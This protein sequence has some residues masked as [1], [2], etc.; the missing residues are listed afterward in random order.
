[1]DFF[2]GYRSPFGY[3]NGENGGVDSYGVDHSGFNTQDELQYQTLRANRESE[4]AEDLGRSR[5]FGGSSVPI[6]II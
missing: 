6:A 4:M 2:G 3:E 1:M 5:V